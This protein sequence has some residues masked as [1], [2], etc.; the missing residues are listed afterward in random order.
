LATFEGI[1]VESHELHRRLH[2]RHLIMLSVGGTIASGF[3]LFIGQAIGVAGPSV[4][5][6]FAVA[7]IIGICVM[8]C[9]SELSVNRAVA[10]S[11]AIY[12][13]D[14]MGPLAGFLT[15]WNYWLA[16]V[17]GA[18][19]ESLAA[20]TYFHTF[21]PEVPIWIVAGVIVAIEM[22]VNLVGV[23]FMGEYEFALSTLKTIA[24]AVFCL[25]GIAAILG[26]GF[27]ATGVSNYTSHGGFA[28]K[29]YGAVFTAI[30]TVFFAY[31]G[32]ELVGV[33]AEESVHPERDVPRALMW[34]AGLVALLFIVGSLVLMAIVPWTRASTTSIS[35]FVDALNALHVA[36]IATIL[37]WIVIIASLSSVDGGLYTA[38][39]MFFALAR[40]GYFPEQ[41][42]R[43][44]PRRRVPIVA[45][46]IT[47]L[48]IFF[49]AVVAY[50][51]PTT[52]YVFVASLSTFGFLYAWLMIPTSQLL[53]RLQRGQ[54]YVRNLRWK[55]P[56]YPLTPLLAI[57]A[58]L[59]A[60]I[61][62]FFFGSGNQLGPFKIPGNGLV[63]VIGII[64]TII[65]SIYFL[66]IGSRF[67]HGDVRRQQEEDARLARVAAEST[68]NPGLGD[69]Q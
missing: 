64:W 10:G 41:V 58:V 35:P 60:F 49:G 12:A 19:T 32:I 23:L 30:F 43:T 16:W 57:V 39:R 9:L 36:V 24:L 15:G 45:I 37:N 2:L 1:E 22:I 33:G 21:R 4:V 38:S 29:G 50:F 27:H 34:T 7:G 51:N 53:Y 69:P 14:T 67:R 54:N 52:A 28:P 6:T 65:W 46:F 11:F 68:P 25:I 62:Q 8:A 56:L 42:A 44:H 59:V 26:L 55:V 17:M 47:S 18:A 61:G 40:E 13:R 31:V 48:C 66:A 3:F 63:V 5:I 20:G